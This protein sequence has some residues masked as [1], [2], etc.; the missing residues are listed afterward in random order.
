MVYTINGKWDI[1]QPG[2]IILRPCMIFQ[3]KPGGGPDDFQKVDADGVL[4][5]DK[6]PRLMICGEKQMVY[7]SL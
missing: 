3:A 5:L 6:P 4:A 1:D 2:V 7:K